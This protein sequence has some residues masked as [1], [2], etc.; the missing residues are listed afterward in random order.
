MWPGLPVSNTFRL[1]KVYICAFMLNVKPI[2]YCKAEPST[3]GIRIGHY[4]QCNNFALGIPAGWYLKTLKFALPPTPNQEFALPPK[5]NPDVSLWNICCVG[6][7]SIGAHVGHVHFMLVVSISF[8]LG[9]QCYTLPDS[10]RRYIY[11]VLSCS[12]SAQTL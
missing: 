2:F 11:L 12:G 8:A 6:S 5:P 9:S 10:R 3:L 1:L 4:P 7:P